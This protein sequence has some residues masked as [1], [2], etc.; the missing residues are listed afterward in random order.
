MT[1][2]DPESF[3]RDWCEAWN[4]HDVEAV[5]A[6][7][8]GDAVFTSPVAARVVPESGGVVRGKD[9]LR[10]YWVAALAALPDLHFEVVATYVGTNALV[11]NYRN[12]R[13]QL[14]NEVLIFDGAL[15]R[16]GHGTYLD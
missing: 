3:A 16:E 8:H 4:A 2:P 6:H 14:V 5:L 11:I 12:H 1:I 10:R 13:D 9:A 7:F 15:V